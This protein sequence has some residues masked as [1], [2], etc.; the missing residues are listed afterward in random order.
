MIGYSSRGGGAA[1]PAVRLF[2]PADCRNFPDDPRQLRLREVADLYYFPL[3]THLAKGTASSI[4]TTLSNWERLT[5]DPPVGAIDD[6][7]LARFRDAFLT[8]RS[9]GRGGRSR[10]TVARNLRQL[11]TIF[12][13]LGPR[14]DRNPGGQGILDQVP[15]CRGY[16]VGARDWIYV[17]VDEMDAV[18]RACEV[19][20]WPATGRAH[21]CALWRAK[22]AS[23]WAFGWN[24]CDMYAATW[25]QIAPGDGSLARPCRD[26]HY[27]SF[28]RAKT[29]G[30]KPVLHLPFPRWLAKI[31]AHLRSSPG[32]IFDCSIANVRDRNAQR[33][34]ILDA[35]GIPLARRFT[36][37]DL[38]PTCSTRL[39]EIIPGLGAAVLG[40]LPRDVNSRFYNQ[41]AARMAEALDAMPRPQS[42]G[43]GERQLRLFE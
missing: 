43:A 24:P 27:L 39:N 6:Q 13:L 18:Y 17:S 31:F 23:L 10:A 1:V 21:P 30:E 34:A 35:A 22:F 16:K 40:H 5:D 32:R 42:F 15:H 36:F 37:A 26:R 28:T 14:G 11:K 41:W 38:R 3:A 12:R 8:D 9:S 4:R 25:S 29:A 7:T 19:A 33:D 2:D 20:R